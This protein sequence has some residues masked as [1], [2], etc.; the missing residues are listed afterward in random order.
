MFSV[1]AS[2]SKSNRL[3]TE[4]ERLLKEF[5]IRIS[6]YNFFNFCRKK[7]VPNP[8]IHHNLDPNTSMIIND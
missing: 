4:L 6:Y 7:P 1:F 3:L 2:S 5:C 8:R